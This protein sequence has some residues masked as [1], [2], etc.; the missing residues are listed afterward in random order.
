MSDASSLDDKWTAADAYE[1]F[2]GRWSHPLAERFVRWLGAQAG[3][4]W[5]DVGCGTGALTSAI[6]RLADPASVVACDPSEAFVEHTRRRIAEPRV[7]VVVG[8]AGHLPQ[9]PDG[10]D[11][12]VS[13]L[14][15]NFLGDPRGAI[16]EMRARARPGGVVA[17]YVWDYAGRMEFLRAFWD[18]AVALDP[19]A[20]SL[21]EGVRFPMCEREAFESILHG[22][23]LRD[24]TSS[25]IEIPTRFEAFSDYW[26]PFLAGVGPAPSYAMSLSEGSRGVLRSRLERR[27]AVGPGGTIDL[28]ARAWAVR[29]TVP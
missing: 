16:G 25:A 28:V 13:G 3:L 15:I 6:Q 7:S 11:R 29:G 1:A 9:H 12:V 21:D 10:F 18:E 26:Q 23:G 20:R 14:V 19:S 17:G 8:G 27:C 5:L 2:M 24:V 22:A 4:A